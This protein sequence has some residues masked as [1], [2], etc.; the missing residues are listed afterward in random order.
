MITVAAVAILWAFVIPM[1]KDSLGEATAE[2]VS[3]SIDTAGGYTTWDAESEQ[4]TVQIRRGV[5]EA[6]VSK[7][8]IT[9][10][11]GQTTYSE[12]RD[13]PAANTGITYTI[14]LIGFGKPLTVSISPIYSNGKEGST[15]SEVNTLADNSGDLQWT[16]GQVLYNHSSGENIT[17]PTNYNTHSCTSSYYDCDWNWNENV[18]VDCPSPMFC[19]VNDFPSYGW[20]CYDSSSLISDRC[21][22]GT[23]GTRC[24]AD[25]DCLNSRCAQDENCNF[26]CDTPRCV[27]GNNGDYCDSGSDCKSGV[28]SYYHG[29][30]CSEGLTDVSNCYLGTDCLS[31]FCDSSTAVCK[32][33]GDLD[34]GCGSDA[35]CSSNYCGETN[36][37][38]VLTLT[39]RLQLYWPFNETS[40]TTAYDYSGKGKTGTLINGTLVNQI[41]RI[42]K[43]YK[44]DGVND[45]IDLT[46]KIGV[47]WY[48]PYTVSFWVNG[49]SPMNYSD[50]LFGGASNDFNF[51]GGKL[52]VY[53]GS[54]AKVSS[55]IA[56]T[57]NVWQHWVITR[58]SYYTIKIYLDG[59][60]SASI[61][62]YYDY[63]T[64]APKYLGRGTSSVYFSGMID[65]VAVW[66]R[67]LNSTQV[68]ELYSRT[69]PLK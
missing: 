44:F 55:A 33:S 1:V 22:L 56:A 36:R 18:P 47:S 24:L 69:T 62:N 25:G 48:S 5:D 16:A 45:Y 11:N 2:K 37:C 32:A 20:Y 34:T 31:G 60:L 51:N 61:T 3:L 26:W 52:T 40:G 38:E 68:S 14:P 63:S 65:E 50:F 6:N 42:G 19:T 58:D 4:A 10:F 15:L 41:G 12:I 67:A 13:A 54:T 59:V 64:Y 28:C 29:M 46:G 39:S 57:P 43:G 7:I 30:Y 17:V 9:F 53:S 27:E 49:S 66:Y 23:T 21:T 8:K 35:D